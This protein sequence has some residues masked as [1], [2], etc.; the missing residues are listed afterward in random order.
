MTIKR[1]V[2]WKKK[3]NK[4][5]LSKLFG[6]QTLLSTNE[7]LILTKIRI[8]DLLNINKAENFVHCLHKLT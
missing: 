3:S 2:Q 5:F 4:N 7:C 6:Y 8:N 1:F